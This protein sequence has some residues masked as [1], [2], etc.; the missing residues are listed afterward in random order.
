MACYKREETAARVGEIAL[1]S[2]RPV[3]E[4]GPAFTAGY[5]TA[6]GLGLG[7]DGSVL[8]GA[9][10]LAGTIPVGQIAQTIK[11]TY[12]TTRKIYG[13]TDESDRLIGA[14]IAGSHDAFRA[15]LTVLD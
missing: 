4:I 1:L 13:N 5:T 8:A 14:A 3:D 10:A 11:A 9:A 2:E 12:E 6:K 15:A 7:F